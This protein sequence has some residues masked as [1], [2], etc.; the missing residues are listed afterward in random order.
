VDESLKSVLTGAVLDAAIRVHKEMGPGLLESVYHHC[1]IA[2]LIE[3]RI[4][5]ESMVV[6]PRF[7]R[8]KDI[9]K[10]HVIDILVERE[11]V[12][13]LKA[14]E[15]LLP[16]HEAQMISYHES[17]HNRCRG[18]CSRQIHYFPPIRF[19]QI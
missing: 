12:V 15:E 9:N 6:V 5:V 1:L 4:N 7:Y 8:G 17:K 18:I 13:E 2:E 11:I 10:Q 16:V 19:I 14:V 3:R